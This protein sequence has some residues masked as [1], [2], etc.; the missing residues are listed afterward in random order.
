MHT[1]FIVSP[2]A[3]NQNL[4]KKFSEAEATFERARNSLESG[5]LSIEHRRYLNSLLTGMVVTEQVMCW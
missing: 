3:D 5:E 1:N 2:K 4:E